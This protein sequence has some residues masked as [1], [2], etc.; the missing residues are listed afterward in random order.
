MHLADRVGRVRRGH[1]RADA[2]A[3]D[4]ERLRRAADRDGALGHP[5]ER[6]DGNVLALVMDVL[7]D[8]V[9][10]RVGVVPPAQLGDRFEL[11]P[12]QHP[13]RRVVR[14]AYNDRAGARRER[15]RQPVEVELLRR[16]ERHVHRLRAAQDRVRPVILIERL[17]HDH[18]VAGID[19]RQ[20]RR[21]HRF[22]GAAGD[23]DLG[24]R[25][26]GHPVPVRVLAGERVP[27][28]LGP[29]GDGV[30]VH[31][32]A[33][34]L[35]R[36]LFQDVGGGKVREPLRE[37]DGA[38]LAREPGHPADHRLRERVGTSGRVHRGG[39]YKR[40][41][42]AKQPGAFDLPTGLAS[43]PYGRFPNKMK[44]EVP[45]SITIVVIPMT[46]PPQSGPLFGLV[47][48]QVVLGGSTSQT[49]YVPAGTPVMM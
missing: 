1:D 28:P 23:G 12:R 46:P 49:V 19:D 15:G 43:S 40:K 3:G 36:R 24:L 21:S 11:A 8:L 25:V 26:H 30:L 37:I 7:V 48:C 31:V 14:A 16:G 33:N 10:H 20:Q 5:V 35:R 32:V 18:F 47:S 38:V 27:E 22:G 42:P 6:R 39:S 13:A 29:P 41:A 34:R 17:E 9:R 2:P 4:A 45:P 44:P